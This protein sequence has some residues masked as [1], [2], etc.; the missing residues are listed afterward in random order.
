MARISTYETDTD[1]SNLDLLVGSE[2]YIDSGVVK[3]RTKNY[4]IGDLGNFFGISVGA[5]NTYLGTFNQDGSFSYSSAFATQVTTTTSAQ[6]FAAATDVTALTA[7]VTN[8]K[9]SA[10]ASFTTVNQSIATETTARTN[11]ITSLTATVNTNKSSADASFTSVNS[12]IATETSARTSAVNTLTSSVN[13]KPNIFRQSSVPTAEAPKDIWFNT[14]DGNRMYVAT[15]AGDD[16]ITSGEWE[17]TTDTRLAAVV[18]SAATATTNIGTLTNADIAKAAQITELNSQFT[19]NGTDINGL[20]SNTTIAT[21]V[22]NAESS[23]VSTANAARA[24][25][26][27]ALLANISKVFR[28]TSA[29]AVTEPVNSIWYDTDDNNKPYVLVAGTPRVWTAVNDPTL[30]T[31][32]SVTTVSDAVATVNGNLSAGYSLMVNAGGSIAGMKVSSTTNNSGVSTSDVVFLADQFAIKTS[33]GTKQPFTVSGDTVTIDGT[34]KIGSTSASDIETKANSATQASDYGTIRSVAGATSGNVAG[35]NISQ[36]NINSGASANTTQNI[37]GYSGSAGIIMNSNGSFHSPNFFINADGSAGFKGTLTVGSTDLTTSNT[38]NENTTKDNVGLGNVDNSNFNSSGNVVGGAVG[39][40]SITSTVLKQGSGGYADTNTGFYLDSSGQFSLRNNFTVD[41]SGNVNLV[42]DITANS[43]SFTGVLTSTSGTIGGWKIGG[44]TIESASNKVVLDSSNNNISFAS[45]SSGNVDVLIGNNS[46]LGSISASGAPTFSPSTVTSVKDATQIS[47]NSVQFVTLQ[48]GAGSSNELRETGSS[49]RVLIQGN[50]ATSGVQVTMT[51]TLDESTYIARATNSQTMS[52]NSIFSAEVGVYYSSYQDSGYSTFT[53]VGGIT[54]GTRSS[55]TH[56]LV[57]SPT[58][59]SITVTMTNNFNVLIYP[60]VRNVKFQGV[61]TSSG[62]ATLNFRTPT[63]T[64]S[65]INYSIARSELTGGGFQVIKD[66]SN[67]FKVNRQGGSTYSNPFIKSQGRFVHYGNIGVGGNIKLGLPTGSTSQFA[68]IQHDQ[69]TTDALLFRNYSTG[70]IHF[71][72]STNSL[73]LVI[74]NNRTIAFDNYGSGTLTTNANGLI[75]VSSDS[76]LKNEVVKD[77]PGLSEVL[78]LNPKAYTWKNEDPPR[79]EIGF[80][81]D[82][83]KD[84]IPEAAPID[85]NGLYGLLDRGI[86]A[87]LVE[88]IKDQQELIESQK[89][90]IEDL[91]ARVTALES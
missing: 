76:S 77:L 57:I 17:E 21:A 12:S 41:A 48:Q 56:D 81:A 5:V 43:G 13:L 54:S 18:T 6:G 50:S 82:E 32:A 51:F 61:M 47:Q 64:A 1:I 38:L 79:V 22:A 28:Q 86:I 80:F 74:N 34:L 10:D 78:K 4:K 30:A 67:Y 15:A 68:M 83:V 19:F 11:A 73:S 8:N 14:G 25:A 9:N 35:W 44:T 27:T 2:R 45:S 60:V 37:S 40:V 71:R 36:Y 70:G 89:T 87:A 90:L 66:I 20:A 58:T 65:A 69:G 63:I 16:Q 31:S 42:G 33:S 75:S 84:V 72:N 24:A 7:T 88:S 23:A 52:A 91:T 55:G 39:P 53:T 29:P 59:V 3:F 26:E 85:N 46:N 49:G 62:N